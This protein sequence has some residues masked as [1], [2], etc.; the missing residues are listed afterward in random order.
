VLAGAGS[1]K[2]RVITQ[3]IAYLVQDCG[4]QPRNVAAI[5]FTNKAA[6]EMQER[7]GKL[8]PRHQA[9]DLQISTFPLAR[10]PHPA[11][12]SQGAGLQAAFLD[13]RFGRLRR[14]HR[15]S[16]QD[17]GQGD[18][19]PDCSP[20]FPT[21]R[22]RWSARKRLARLASTNT[23]PGGH[24]YLSYEATLKAYQAV[25]FDDLIG[26]P[27]TLF[28]QHPGDHRQVAEPPALPAGR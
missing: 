14:H 4:F 28:Q 2:T 6:K 1:G 20:S 19:A 18:A 24:A 17:G 21:G 25:D 23:K 3:K 26:L 12:R 8:L 22:M 27:V 7:I 9:D 13:F 10:R 15:R 16:C 5:T 11:R